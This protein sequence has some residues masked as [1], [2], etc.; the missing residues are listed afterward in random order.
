MTIV[1]V[2][3]VA[4]F[5]FAVCNCYVY[6]NFN[7]VPGDNPIVNAGVEEPRHHHTRGSHNNSAAYHRKKGHTPSANDL[8]AERHKLLLASLT[9]PQLYHCKHS[10]PPP[11]LPIAKHRASASNEDIWLYRNIFSKLPVSEVMSG[12]YIEMGAL[13]G[14]ENS[15]TLYFEKR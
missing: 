11:K 15:N 13:D 10:G 9:F 5:C 4:W 8:D 12:F 1:S 2:T 7:S 14:L 3:A 6:S